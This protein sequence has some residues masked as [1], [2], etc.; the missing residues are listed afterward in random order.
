MGRRWGNFALDITQ[1][2]DV[3]DEDMRQASWGEDY[4]FWSDVH[5]RPRPKRSAEWWRQYHASR[6]DK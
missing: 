4:D 3:S 2:H 6:G 1:H 5:S